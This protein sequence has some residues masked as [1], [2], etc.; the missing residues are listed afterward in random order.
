LN[1]YNATDAQL[2][3]DFQH[4]FPLVRRP[5]LSIG[6]H[7][8]I[9]EDEVIDSFGKLAK[10]GAIS[11]I[12][13]VFSPGSIGVSTLAA[14]AV[15]P[16][17]IEEVA[18][19][20]NAYPEINHNYEREHEYNLWFVATAPNQPWLDN[21]LYGIADHF[22]FPMIVLPMV[23]RYHIDLGFDLNGKKCHGRG[24]GHHSHRVDLNP[25]QTS[26]VAALQS[27]IRLE[28]E[29]FAAIAEAAGMDEDGVLSQVVL[30]RMRGV[31]KRFGVVVRHHELGYRENAMA[32]WDV[33]DELTAELGK[34]A[35][36][37][38]GV[39]LC[40]RRHR[41]RPDW[42]YNLFCMVHGTER[43]VVEA[44]I[45]RLAENA[46]LAAFPSRI[47]FSRRR[48]KQCG[49]QYVYGSGST[50]HAH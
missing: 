14:L 2:L 42:P 39:T 16:E 35:A 15:P 30:W 24:D 8:G 17:R 22:G 10:R 50:S 43:S 29:P 20:L 41:Q 48:F 5:F 44:Q 23:E 32:V 33:P 12:G 47:L 45:A 9:E 25:E 38:E 4:V 49:A 19:W 21:V 7:L 46:G 27:G 26:V 37:Q 18:L 36:Q 13:P 1:G 28:P 11:R 34:I 6:R 31:I 40:Y 3:N